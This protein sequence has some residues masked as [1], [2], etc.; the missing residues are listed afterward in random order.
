MTKVLVNLD[1]ICRVASIRKPGKGSSPNFFRY[2][3]FLTED[4]LQRG[5]VLGWIVPY[6]QRKVWHKKTFIQTGFKTTPKFDKFLK[7]IPKKMTG[8]LEW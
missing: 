6:R 5:I 8:P 7:R 4:D 2:A 1:F 3:S